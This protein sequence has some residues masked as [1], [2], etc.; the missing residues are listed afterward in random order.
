M[1]FIISV[2]CFLIVALEV[3]TA[4]RRSKIPTRHHYQKPLNQFRLSPRTWLTLKIVAI[5]IVLCQALALVSFIY[6]EAIQAAGFAAYGAIKS[7]D[8]PIAW[9]CVKRFESVM[10]AAQD[11]QDNL[12]WI[13]WWAAPAYDSY[14]HKSAPAQLASFYA[15]GVTEELWDHDADRWLIRH[16]GPG[17]VFVD[18]WK[19]DPIDRLR[20]RGFRP[21]IIWPD[22]SNPPGTGEADLPISGGR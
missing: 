15:Q 21:E 1:I 5:P 11:F 8:A 18:T 14:F 22:F 16:S 12:G 20:A 7:K 2:M 13:A 6:E 10:F 9:D 4:V 19:L 3:V 17:R